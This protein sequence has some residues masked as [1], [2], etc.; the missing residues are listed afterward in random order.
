MLAELEVLKKRLPKGFTKKLADEFKV[1]P[2]T[3]SH[4]LKGR[5]RR[6]DIIERA[7]EMGEKYNELE[8][9]LKNVIQ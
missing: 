4:A 1:S 8:L 3:V 7:I 5:Y 6:L 2:M 9:R